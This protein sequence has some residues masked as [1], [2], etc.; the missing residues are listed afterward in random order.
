MGEDIFVAKQPKTD[1]FTKFWSEYLHNIFDK[2]ARILTAHFKL[3][4]ADIAG[5]KYND[6]I[7][8]KDAY[9]RINKISNYAI[10]KNL[11]TKVELIKILNFKNTLSIAGCNLQVASTSLFGYISFV[12]PDT[13]QIA[14]ANQACCEANGGIWYGLLCGVKKGARINTKPSTARSSRFNDETTLGRSG[15]TIKVTGEIKEFADSEN[16]NDGQVASWNTTDE[17]VNWIDAPETSPSGSDTYVQFNDGGSFGSYSTFNFNK[18]SGKLSA[19]KF[20]GEHLGDNIGTGAIRAAGY[21][22]YWYLT[23]QDFMFG[24]SSTS[25]NYSSTSGLTI[26]TWQ[27]YTSY[28]K[29]IATIQIPKGYK[30]VSVFIKGSANLS[31]SAGVTSWSSSSGGFAGSGVVNTEATGLN[32]TSVEGDFYAI[33]IQGSGSTQSIYGARLTLEEV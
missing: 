32:W 26:R 10:G 4:S 30:V 17:K 6:K 15:K 3:T 25:P 28:G 27:Y 14:T 16:A 8:I 1:T 2:D 29:Y 31:W 18:Y 23:P 5:F 33:S 9:Y 22:K 7:F 19:V 12:N 24:S 21:N 11:S 20:F 13:G